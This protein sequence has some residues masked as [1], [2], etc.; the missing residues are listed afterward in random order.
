MT[1]GGGPLNQVLFFLL[2]NILKNIF[3]IP[4]FAWVQFLATVD[5]FTMWLNFNSRQYIHISTN[6]RI[7]CCMLARDI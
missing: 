3:N 2:D 4:M 5:S 6:L 1:E 7:E